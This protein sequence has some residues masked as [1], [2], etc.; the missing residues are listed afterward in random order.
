MYRWPVGFEGYR[1]QV[2]VN[3]EGRLFGGQTIVHPRQETVVTLDADPPLQEWVRKRLWSQAIHLAWGTFE[4]GDGRYAI[5]FGDRRV[6]HPRGQ[7]IVLHGGQSLSWY[8]VNDQRYTMISRAAS[9][10]ERCVNSIERYESFSDGRLYAVHYVMTY[11]SEDEGV[12]TGMESYVNEFVL[13][14]RMLLPMRRIVSHVTKGGVK[15]RV[16]Q[17]SN[18]RIVA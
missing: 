2:L 3:D 4:E 12:L 5:T 6:D 17:L 15:T 1:A 7:Q 13:H 14:Q 9:G 11:F 10:K 18:H 16:I 8:R